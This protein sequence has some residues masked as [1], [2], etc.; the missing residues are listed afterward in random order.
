[1]KKGPGLSTR[2]LNLLVRQLEK[3]GVD[4]VAMLHRAGIERAQ[5]Q[6]RDARLPLEKIVAAA[7]L[8]IGAS[9]RT[10]LGLVIG[11]QIGLGQ[12]G[13]LGQAMLCSA[14]L[15]DAL[16][17]CAAH[18][19]MVSQNFSMHMRRRGDVCEITWF[20]AG[21]KPYDLVVLSYDMTIAAFH[22]LFVQILAD[23]VP[24]YDVYLPTAPAHVAAYRAFRPARFHFAQGGQLALR[25]AL[26][27]E[28]LNAPMP[29]ADEET[30][31]LI[32]ERLAM[33]GRNKPEPGS[34]GGW[35]RKM[36]DD[37]TGH[38]PTQLELA[39]MV[40]LSSSALARHLSAEGT[41]FRSLANEVRHAKACRLLTDGQTVAAVADQL[42]YAHT[43]NFV[44]AFRKLAGMCPS[45]FAT[46]VRE[47][48]G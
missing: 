31:A 37:C 1:M 3:D 8:L 30:L 6:H 33:Q 35:V 18:Y 34:W 2:H 36:L 22:R 11:K 9:G 25:I 43:P 44:R 12:W 15:L 40:N 21:Q 48:S 41:A 14:T 29:M 24:P 13:D 26:P 39:S 46:A 19:A 38:M 4:C 45:E 42:G 10:D 27:Y 5:L 7:R 28:A 20:P 17:C 23:E 16:Q 32:R 47:A